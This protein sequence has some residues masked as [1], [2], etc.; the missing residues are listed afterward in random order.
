M[1]A[2]K[3]R[4]RDVVIDQG[5]GGAQDAFVLALGEDDAFRVA[6]GRLEH[7]PHQGAGAEHEAF[8]FAAVG[9]EIA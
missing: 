8:Q 2:Q 7:R 6:R 1:A 9:V 3:D 4:V 5:L